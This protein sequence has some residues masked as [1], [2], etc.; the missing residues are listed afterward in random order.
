MNK[1]TKEDIVEILLAI[2]G[3]P[4]QYIIGAIILM[5]F[6]NA[7]K[8]MTNWAIF[9]PIIAFIFIILEVLTPIMAGKR[10]WEKIKRNFRRFFK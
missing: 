9:F 4:G 6:W 5:A 8:D 2:Y 10:L 1:Q 3:V 7:M